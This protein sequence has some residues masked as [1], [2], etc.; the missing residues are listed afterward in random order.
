MTQEDLLFWSDALR[1]LI[2]AEQESSK[3]GSN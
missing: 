1:R 3:S 2:E